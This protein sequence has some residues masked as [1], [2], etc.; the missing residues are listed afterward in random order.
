MRCK[1]N[2]CH[3]LA[4]LGHNV[5]EDGDYMKL[6]EYESLVFRVLGDGRK[7]IASIRTDNWIVG[8]TSHDVWQS[9]LFAR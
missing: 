4:Q 6:A 3:I 1:F 9:F 8:G 7:Y 5:Q 2:S